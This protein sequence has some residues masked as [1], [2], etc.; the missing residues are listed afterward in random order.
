MVD[1]KTHTDFIQY[2]IDIG[3]D[4][5]AQDN[6]G[7]TA[8]LSISQNADVYHQLKCLIENGADVNT[9]GSD[10][11]TALDNV[12]QSNSDP[13]TIKLLLESGAKRSSEL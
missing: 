6:F 3:I 8:L 5:N 9:V 13:R 11:N 7:N 4:V 10:G 12:I 2:L 1:K